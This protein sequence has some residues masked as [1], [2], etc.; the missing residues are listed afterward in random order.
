MSADLTLKMANYKL[1][2][3]KHTVLFILSA[4]LDGMVP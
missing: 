4:Q 1:K 3:K 2:S